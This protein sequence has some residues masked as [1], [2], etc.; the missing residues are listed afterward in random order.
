M[1]ILS[2]AGIYFNR[3]VISQM[4]VGHLKCKLKKTEVFLSLLNFSSYH[5]SIIS[6]N[7]NDSELTHFNQ[8][9]CV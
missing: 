7:Q 2:R 9:F 5:I 3:L 4:Y 1:Y 8:C 6:S